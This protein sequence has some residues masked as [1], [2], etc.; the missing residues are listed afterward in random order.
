MMLI[1]EYASFVLFGVKIEIG[2]GML[3]GFVVTVIE[4]EKF[5]S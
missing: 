3:S 5:F 2:I 4:A 1:L